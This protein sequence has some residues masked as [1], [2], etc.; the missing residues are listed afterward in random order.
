MAVE[1]SIEMGIDWLVSETSA[2]TVCDPLPTG[3]QLYLAI[4]EADRGI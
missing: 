2:G 1:A 4:F 3:L